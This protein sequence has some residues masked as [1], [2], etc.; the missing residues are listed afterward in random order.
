MPRQAILTTA[1]WENLTH[2]SFFYCPHIL[3][4]KCNIFSISYFIFT[5]G[6]HFNIL[7]RFIK[8]NFGISE[9]EGVGPTPEGV[10]LGP[11]SGKAWFWLD[12]AHI[13]TRDTFL[14]PL[15]DHHARL[16]IFD[17]DRVR[18]TPRGSWVK[19]PLW[20][21][22]VWIRFCYYSHQGYIFRSCQSLSTQIVKFST[23]RGQAHPGG[24]QIRPPCFSK[25]HAIM[26]Y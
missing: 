18:P 2:F 9:F 26:P 12:F 6:A 13:H 23:L 24:V 19:A 3:S 21:S 11:L 4:H 10:G 22:L 16:Q 8:S 25:D 20:Q 14:H 17:P 7:W 15:K 5:P 1:Q